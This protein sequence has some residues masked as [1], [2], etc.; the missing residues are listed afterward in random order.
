MPSCNGSEGRGEQ[1]LKT[2]QNNAII[3]D[4]DCIISDEK[5]KEF[6]NKFTETLVDFGFPR[7][8][9]NIMVSNPYWCRKE[10][11]FKDLIYDGL[12]NHHLIIFMN[13]AI[14]YDAVCVSGK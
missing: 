8:E 10:S 7:C 1:I 14:F 5:L 13:L 12:H 9:G 4:D 2:D 11:N 3:M 6:T